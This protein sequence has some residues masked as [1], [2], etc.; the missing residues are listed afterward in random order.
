MTKFDFIIIGGGIIGMTTARE[1]AMRG[2]R[3]AIID[4]GCLGKE[5][6]WAAG[7]ILSS[8]RPWVENPASAELSERGKMLYSEYSKSLFSETDIDP[9]YVRSG[10]VIADTT[11]IAD[12]NNW[13]KSRCIKVEQ[14]I[15]SPSKLIKIPKQALLLPDIAQ[16]R[17]PRLLQS[18]HKSLK[19]LS[20]SI[21][22]NSE[23]KD[24]VIK[25]NRFEYVKLGKERI[26]A[27]A[28]IISAGSWSSTILG[29]PMK[30]IN[31]RPIHG[32]MMCLRPAEQNLKTIILDGGHY[33][34]P[35]LDGHVLI[36]STMEDIGFSKKITINAKQEL[37]D[38]AI[39]IW[40]D[41][42]S[43]PIVKHW[44][45]LRPS[46]KSG[47]PYIGQLHDYKNICVN[48]GHF[49]KG[50]L[51]APSSAELLADYL[52]GNSSFM[53]IEQLRIEDQSHPVKLA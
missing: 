42:R 51:Q 47:H 31:I 32:Q 22:E 24:L 18:L 9:E 33:F 36:G 30:E 25:N 52:T 13:A 29:D 53:D 34:I 20:V 41:L 16:L 50:I 37:L 43:A 48:A 17:P 8:M 3:V 21:Y 11:H 28:L 5:A 14:K 4:K 38:W 10:L 2:S 35:R 19:Q 27:D 39:S 1:L 6:S 40:P 46:T 49:R 26:A 44:S 45:G 7:G 12:I 23:V 15:T